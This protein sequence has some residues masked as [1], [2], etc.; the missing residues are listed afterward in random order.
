MCLIL[1]KQNQNNQTK[2]KIVEK[3]QT[4][5]IETV[6]LVRDPCSSIS[7]FI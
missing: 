5:Q 1:G 4:M 6:V 2:P 7:Y 3:Y